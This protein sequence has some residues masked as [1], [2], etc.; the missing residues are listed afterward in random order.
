MEEG[1]NWTEAIGRVVAHAAEP[2]PD[3]VVVVL[4]PDGQVADAL[5]GKV[6]AVHRRDA[7]HDLPAGVSIV[8]LHGWLRRRLPDAQR[9][10]IRAL[11]AALPSRG[12]V[13][14][15]DAMW[16]LPLD[17]VDA[18][19]QF[20]DALAHAQPVAV[21]ESWLR[22]AGFLPDTFRLAPG[23]AVIVGVRT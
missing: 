7:L 5:S 9:D 1:V 4:A 23:A 17:Q 16:S 11:A 13:I 3:D 2:H 12:L 8:C 19:E 14:I 20:G 15:G 18:P 21:V 6:R 10:T 22:D